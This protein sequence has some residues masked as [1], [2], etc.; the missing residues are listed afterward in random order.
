MQVKK[1][2][3]ELAEAER[4]VAEGE[5]VRRRL[6]NQ[7]QE[8]KGGCLR[9][10][11]V[12]PVRGCAAGGGGARQCNRLPLDTDHALDSVVCYQHTTTSVH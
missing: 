11:C 1:L 10:G 2:E 7:I 6:H 4:K 3:K 9:G 8:L 12:R 5:V